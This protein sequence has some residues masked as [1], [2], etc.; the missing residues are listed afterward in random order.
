MA[1][2]DEGSRGRQGSAVLCAD[3]E[4]VQVNPGAAAQRDLQVAST[5]TWLLRHADH[6]RTRHCS[7]KGLT[8]RQDWKGMFL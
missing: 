4:A 6:L 5:L 1:L 3:S 8:A 7:E 2:P